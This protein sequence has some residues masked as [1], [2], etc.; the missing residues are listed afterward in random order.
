VGTES[1]EDSRKAALLNVDSSASKVIEAI[2]AGRYSRPLGTTT[3]ASKKAQPTISSYCE[4]QYSALGPTSGRIEHKKPTRILSNPCCCAV[5]RFE[6]RTYLKLAHLSFVSHL[7]FV[8]Y[9]YPD[10]P[11]PSKGDLKIGIPLPPVEG[12]G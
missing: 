8:F 11:S 5:A 7:P 10:N 9:R 3:H 6:K 12:L 2:R 4:N 1:P